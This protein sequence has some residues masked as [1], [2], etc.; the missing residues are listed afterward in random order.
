MKHLVI[1]LLSTVLLSSK[2][3]AQIKWKT[4]THKNGFTVLLPDYFKQGIY[5]AML[6]YYD[7]S[8]DSSINVVVETIGGGTES[9]LNK[10][11]DS[12]IE[13]NKNIVY[14]VLKTR[15]YVVS[16]MDDDFIY[17]DKVILKNGMLYRL[18][19]RYPSQKKLAVDKILGRIGKSFK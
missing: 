17:Y 9:E 8:E 10:N 12:E 16:G 4:F 13:S 15:W 19:I 1:L 11:Y 7:N 14:S 6:Q 5:V 18:T 3:N 2:S